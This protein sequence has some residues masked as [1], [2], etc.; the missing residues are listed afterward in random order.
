MT[1]RLRAEE[2]GV[3]MALG[4][5]MMAWDVVGDFGELS[6]TTNEEQLRFGQIIDT[7]LE[8]IHWETWSTV[9]CRCEIVVENSIQIFGV[10][11][12]FMAIEQP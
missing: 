5:S 6:R 1:P 7:R 9:V 3:M 2:V 4:L 12:H 11:A 8:G 10:V